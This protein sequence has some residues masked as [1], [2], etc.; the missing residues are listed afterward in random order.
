MQRGKAKTRLPWNFSTLAYAGSRIA[1]VAIALYLVAHIVVISTAARNRAGFDGL[2]QRLHAPFWLAMEMLLVLAV[3][4]HGIN[5]I[6]LML[7]EAG[8][9]VRKERRLFW[10]AVAVTVVLFAVGAV[11]YAP[12]IFERL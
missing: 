6:R 1:G 8:V 7:I 4:F 5:G 9:E 10:Y 3:I 2:M 12:I 11:I